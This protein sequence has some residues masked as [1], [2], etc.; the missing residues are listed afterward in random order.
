LRVLF[1]KEKDD[2]IFYFLGTHD[3]LDTYVKNLLK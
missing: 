2:L 3:Q 1:K